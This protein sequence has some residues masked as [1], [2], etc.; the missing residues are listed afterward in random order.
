MALG[1]AGT[2]VLP[3]PASSQ[4]SLGKMSM[5]SIMPTKHPASTFVEDAVQAI[6]KE[7][8]GAIEIN[9]FPSSMLGSEASMQ[10]QLRSGAIDFVVHSC[11]F[12]QTVVPVAGIPTVAYAYNDYKTLWASLDGTLG[13]YIKA[14][15]EK[16]GMTAF[17]IVDAGFR[18]ITTSVRPINTVADLNRL[19]IRVPPSPLLTSLFEMLGAAPVNITAGELYTS[20]QAKVADGMEGSL[21]NVDTFKVFEVQKYCSKTS[22]AWD[23]LWMIAR[24]RSW[25]AFPPEVRE[26]IQRNFEDYAVKQQKE[27]ARMEAELEGT[28]K[29]K[30]LI[31][32]EPERG[33]FREALELA[34]Y[35]KQWKGK[36]GPDAWAKLE[37]YT[38]PLGA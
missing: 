11:S 4:A 30:G 13:A 32:N 8:N 14:A 38:G 31:I 37:Q 7:T 36:F 12:L 33:Q 6:K 20:L 23:G 5:G 16:A 34:W 15:L 2:A 10:S 19:K 28:L 18:H 17:K 9:F 27:F 22:H 3:K 24:T 29:S 35:Y 25:K 1:T 21:V 26:V